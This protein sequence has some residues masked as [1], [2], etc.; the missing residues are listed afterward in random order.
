MKK[1]HLRNAQI[2]KREVEKKY[3]F[4]QLSQATATRIK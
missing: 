4:Y 2:I 1:K 3:P